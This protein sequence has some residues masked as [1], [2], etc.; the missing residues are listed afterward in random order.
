[1][2]RL[3]DSFQTN[4]SASYRLLGLH[5][6]TMGAETFDADADRTKWL[7]RG[8][9]LVY[10]QT[11]PEVI[12]VAI[13]LESWTTA[14]PPPSGPWAGQEEGE[15]ELLEGELQLQTID[16]GM[17]EI[18]L[19]L[20]SPGTYRMRWQWVFNP[21]IGRTFTSPL[22]DRFGAVLDNPGGHE[23]D[24]KGQDQFCLVQIWRTVAA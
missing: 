8:P 9:G 14:P 21:D 1:M 15:V 12:T 5:D 24:L 3:L 4:T 13:R 19:V 20:P 6:T 22:K 16:C 7:L 10:L 18:P 2:R 23:A 17:E 11:P